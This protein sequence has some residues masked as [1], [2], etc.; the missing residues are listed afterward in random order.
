[1]DPK[2]RLAAIQCFLL[3]MDGTVYLGRQVFP[4]ARRFFE[5]LS[6]TGRRHL[7]LTNNSSRTSAEYV[8]KL[9]ALDLP[10]GEGAVYTSGDAT[11][12]YFVQHGLG[13]RIYLLGTTS[14]CQ[15]F[16][17]EGFTLT[18]EQPDAVLLAFDKELTYERVRVACRLIRDGVPYFATHPDFTC[19]VEEGY[20]PDAGAMAEMIAAATDGARPQVIGKPERH[21]ID[22]ALARAGVGPEAAAFVGDRLMTDIAA[23]VRAGILSILV[24]S[25]ETTREMLRDAQWQPDL[26]YPDIGALA[27][28]LDERS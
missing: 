25:G 3:D 8:D 18:A 24:L 21:I 12:E 20:I 11:I 19:P 14:L 9:A 15:Q 13:R 1:M 23:G 6:R 4:G 10:G 22:G 26:V 2:A 27:E 28:D 16:E 17:R 5:Q 7:F